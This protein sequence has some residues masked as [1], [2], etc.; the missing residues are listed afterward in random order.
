METTIGTHWGYTGIMENKTE[1]TICGGL[2]GQRAGGWWGWRAEGE[3]PALQAFEDCEL[4]GW[5]GVPGLD[6]PPPSNPPFSCPRHPTG[7]VPKI[8]GPL[9][10]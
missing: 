8:M 5:K 4:E 3:C 6:D 9:W 7:F 2:E 10:L 1:P